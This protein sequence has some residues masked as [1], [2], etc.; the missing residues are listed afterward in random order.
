MLIC[1]A[2][3]RC[4]ELIKKMIECQNDCCFK[5]IVFLCGWDFVSTIVFIIDEDMMMSI[6]GRV[7]REGKWG[8]R[9]GG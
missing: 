8:W 7:E 1:F 6:R 9:G 3:R 4:L 2:G 5:A